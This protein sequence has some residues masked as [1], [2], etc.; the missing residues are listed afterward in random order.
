MTQEAQL[1]PRDQRDALYQLKYW[2]TVVRMTQTHRLSAS[3]ALSPTA[4]FYSAA[5]IVL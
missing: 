1:L 4:T 3:G 5:C 2:S